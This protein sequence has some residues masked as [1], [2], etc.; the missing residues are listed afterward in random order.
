MNKKGIFFTILTLFVMLNLLSLASLYRER[1]KMSLQD[2]I[3]VEEGARLGLFRN[4]LAWES[5][6]AIGGEN[7]SM[8]QSGGE[9]VY[10]L[11]G[12]FGYGGSQ[13]DALLAFVG[14]SSHRLPF[15]LTHGNFSA[16]PAEIII[17]ED[18]HASMYLGPDFFELHVSPVTNLTGVSLVVAVDEDGDSFNDE[19]VDDG[20]FLVSFVFVGPSLSS[21][22]VSHTI[23]LNVSQLPSLLAVSSGNKLVFIDA[24]AGSRQVIRAYPSAGTF[25]VTSVQ[26][27]FDEGRTAQFYF[28]NNASIAG[29]TLSASRL[30]L[31][32]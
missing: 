30:T 3:L 24:V 10:S 13:I 28:N 14:S 1:V 4:G 2:A 8:S 29:P 11:E 18:P 23:A 22:L 17:A 9:V 27:F 7:F 32:P 31:S 26:L 20:D 19:W 5:F 16:S 12:N 15:T 25:N 6:R 21:T